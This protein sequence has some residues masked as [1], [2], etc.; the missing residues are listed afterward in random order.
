MATYQEI[1]EM[2][3]E[4][5]VRFPAWIEMNPEY[6]NS[7][8][9]QRHLIRPVVVELCD[10]ENDV[11]PSIYTCHGN[12]ELLGYGKSWRLWYANGRERPDGKQ[13]W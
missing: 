6:A 12:F 2:G 10:N 11:D 13:E 4:D 5:L 9:S 8:Y 3:R 7:E 1:L